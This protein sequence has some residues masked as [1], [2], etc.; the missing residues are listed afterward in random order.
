M[1]FQAFITTLLKADLLFFTIFFIIEYNKQQTYI[2]H[3]RN[4][5]EM[6]CVDFAFIIAKVITRVFVGFNLSAT[7][8]YSASIFITSAKR[9]IL[10]V[11]VLIWTISLLQVDPEKSD[12]EKINCTDEKFNTVLF[13][14]ETNKIG[15]VRF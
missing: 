7:V 1:K 3:L 14:H 9:K 4:T 6:Q 15:T 2:A 13:L 5:Y 8:V 12:S 11:L 10:I